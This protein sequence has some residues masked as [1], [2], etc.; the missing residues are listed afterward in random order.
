MCAGKVM[1]RHCGCLI[2]PRHSFILYNILMI[3]IVGSTTYIRVKYQ[4]S[5]LEV[6]QSNPPHKQLASAHVSGAN[7]LAHSS[8]VLPP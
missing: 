7:S 6:N 4:V 3:F 2:Q 1:R 5:L 8:V